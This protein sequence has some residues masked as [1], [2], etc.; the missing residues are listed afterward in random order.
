[1]SKQKMPAAVHVDGTAGLVG[2]G[3]IISFISLPIVYQFL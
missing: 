1:M 3:I 2:F